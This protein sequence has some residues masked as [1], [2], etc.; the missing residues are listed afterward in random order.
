MSDSCILRVVPGIA[1]IDRN[2][3]WRKKA[4]KRRSTR[5]KFCQSGKR[6]RGVST[7]LRVRLKGPGL[8]ETGQ[9]KGS[10]FESP[11]CAAGETPCRTAGKVPA[12]L[13]MGFDNSLLREGALRVHNDGWDGTNSGH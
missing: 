5:V 1:Y 12:L 13:K 8:L 3:G 11:E 7:G 4:V 9:L 10:T 6:G 2:T